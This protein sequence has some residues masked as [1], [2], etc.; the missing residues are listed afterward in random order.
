MISPNVTIM[1]NDQDVP[2]DTDDLDFIVVEVNRSSIESL[3][4]G[5]TLTTLIQLSE[6]ADLTRTLRDGVCFMIS[7]YDLDDRE[8][9]E[10]AEVKRYFIDLFTQWPFFIHFCSKPL[11][12]LELMFLV[13]SEQIQ[14]AQLPDGKVSL[15]LQ[16]KEDFLEQQCT[17]IRSLN[18]F[19]SAFEAGEYSKFVYSRTEFLRE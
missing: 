3:S 8:L 6:R 10:I 9:Y 18:S 2:Q 14:K 12:T 5:S 11:G 16:I 1:D 17:A 15:S 19:H 13:C 7:G 4:V